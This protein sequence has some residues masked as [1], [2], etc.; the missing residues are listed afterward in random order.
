MKGVGR[1]ATTKRLGQECQI[2]KVDFP[3]RT[4]KLTRPRPNRRRIGCLSKIDSSQIY[5][6]W[7]FVVTRAVHAIIYIGFN[8]VPCRFA[9]Y[10]VSC[11]TLGTMWARFALSLWHP[12]AHTAF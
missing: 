4:M 9:T 12:L 7:I 3:P 2:F 5:L 10:A 1:M 8:H 11:I 6:A